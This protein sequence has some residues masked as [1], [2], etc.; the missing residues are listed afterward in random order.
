MDGRE[1][2]S[3]LGEGGVDGGLERGAGGEG[4]ILEPDLLEGVPLGFNPVQFR[5]VAWQVVEGHANGFELGQVRIDQ[6]T[7]MDVAKFSVPM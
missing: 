7:V 6:L 3:P 5:D 1:F 2:G 4:T